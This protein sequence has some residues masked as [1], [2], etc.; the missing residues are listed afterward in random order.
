M[1]KLDHNFESVMGRIDKATRKLSINP[2]LIK[3]HIE[4]FI[5][6]IASDPACKGIVLQMSITRPQG[7]E[8][9]VTSVHMSSTSID[10]QAAVDSLTWNPNPMLNKEWLESSSNK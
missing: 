8:G 1:D 2:D 9:L 6:G 7:A 4:K 10:S 3:N 5:I